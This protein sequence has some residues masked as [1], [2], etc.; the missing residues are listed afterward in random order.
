M[1]EKTNNRVF[2]F[3]VGFSAFIVATAAAVFSVTGLSMLY[4]GEM[5]YI[6]LAMGSLEF[7]KIIT[8]SYLYRHRKTTG[9]GLKI[10]L[11]IAVLVLMIVTSGGIYGYMTNAYQ[12]ATIGLDKINS[13]TQVLEQRKQNF[14]D[15]RER[16]KVDLESLRSE[17]RSIL[18]S[19]AAEI[20]TNDES[21]DSLAIKYRSYRNR[22]VR[23]QYKPELD[24]IDAQIAKYMVD[25]DFTNV[26]LSN[27]NDNIANQKLDIINTGVDVGP[28]VYMARIFNTTMD[29]VMKWFTLVIVFVFDPLAI[30]LIIAYNAI[31]MRGKQEKQYDIGVDKALPGDYSATYIP[32]DLKDATLTPP[33]GS[34]EWWKDDPFMRARMEDADR[35][36]KEKKE[37]EDETFDLG[38][39][40]NLPGVT[41]DGV[42]FPDATTVGAKPIKQSFDDIQE[43]I[44]ERKGKEFLQEIDD[45]IEEME[46]EV[47]KKRPRFSKPNSK[48]EVS[49]IIK[50]LDDIVGEIKE[51]PTKDI[52]VP[53]PETGA[54][55]YP[56]KKAAESFDNLIEKQVELGQERIV[57][58][59]AKSGD[60]PKEKIIE[61][62]KKVK[63]QNEFF[64]KMR[65]DKK[66]ETEF[67]EEVK[68]KKTLV[69]NEEIRTFFEDAVRKVKKEDQGKIIRTPFQAGGNVNVGH[70]EDDPDIDYSVQE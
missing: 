55:P 42:N 69:S 20:K 57:L 21:T 51:K 63:H 2:T 66:S 12:G 24:N 29:A 70:I 16:L 1:L 9:W 25:L 17:R 44:D 47:E 22:K 35:A 15:E 48:K 5:F 23:E 39:P 6:A 64:D 67:Q 53:D 13:Q 28:L 4:S 37:K 60:I 59:P 34:T 45:E 50:P 56:I 40:D 62:V 38:E 26:R 27:A 68:K 14:T 31:I 65:D 8:A 19:R 49:D 10:Y 41:F 36:L 3:L 18:D 46:K 7:A 43:R 32:F 54:E 52:V 11:S 58:E 61:A 30:A 33:T